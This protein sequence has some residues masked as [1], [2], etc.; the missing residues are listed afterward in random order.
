[1][2]LLHRHDPTRESA[3]RPPDTHDDLP[4]LPDDVAVPDDISGL[5]HPATPQRPAAGVRWLR[6]LPIILLVVAGAVALSLVLR[7][8]SSD[9]PAV[10]SDV[11]AEV[12]GPAAYLPA[13]SGE[14]YN[15]NPAWD[16]FD[17]RLSNPGFHEPLAQF[18]PETN[19]VASS[20][21]AEAGGPVA[22]AYLPAASGEVY[23]FNQQ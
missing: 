4:V 21:S 22:L 23:N 2:R 16:G 1:M 13:T 3:T 8:D 17:S 6:W 5:Q 12:V 15:F 14:V 18:V 9:D 10:A 20:V 19:I 11:A 7:S